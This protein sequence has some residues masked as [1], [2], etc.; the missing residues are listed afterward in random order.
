M[1]TKSNYLKQQQ[2]TRQ[3][4]LDIGEEMGMQKMW[5]YIQIVLRDPDVMGKD[6]FGKERIKKL[7]KALGECSHENGRAF[8]DDP[9]ADYYQE[10]I[11]RQLLEV[12]GKDLQPFH[13]RYP[14][15]K[16]FG[17]DKGRKN[18]R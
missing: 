14:Y 11:D 4:Y 17:Y 5:D 16:R 10:R 1:A 13:E 18:W 8:S 15:I 3:T 6:V 7:Y 12:W 9:E 2:I